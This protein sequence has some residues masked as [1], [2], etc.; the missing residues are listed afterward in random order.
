MHVK[1]WW[2]CSGSDESDS[3]DPMHCSLPSSP[4]HG[5]SK[6]RTVEWIAISFSGRSCQSMGWTHISCIAGRFPTANPPAAHTHTHTD[7][8]HFL[9]SSIYG[10]L[11]CVCVLAV[12]NRAAWCLKAWKIQWRLVPNVSCSFWH[13]HKHA[14]THTRITRLPH[15][16]FYFLCAFGFSVLFKLY[17]GL[18]WMTCFCQKLW[19]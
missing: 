1:W 10:H 3:Y 9:H 5:I 19:W 13:T 4:A 17:L 7:T 2:W 16:K 15:Q 6:A 12:V 11:S 18:F 14:H 8:P